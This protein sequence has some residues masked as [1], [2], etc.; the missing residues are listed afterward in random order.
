[1]NMSM[2]FLLDVKRCSGCQ[3]CI[4][5]CMDQ[6]DLFD[7]KRHDFWRQVF[8]I[9]NGSFP[10]VTISFISVACTQCQET[11]CLLSCPT[12]AIY[13]D[14]ETGI[15][16][17]RQEFCIGCHSCSLACPFGVP[18]FDKN[19]KMEKCQMCR[20]RIDN[21]LEPACV[22]TCPTKALKYGDINELS[23]QVAIKSSSRILSI[24][25]NSK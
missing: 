21:G 15:I 12:G 23:Q 1:M 16:C 13:K 14:E 9:E 7:R 18:R 2:T 19:G 22:H 8:K 17:I 11:P 24:I 4:V 20:E 25:S 10:E 6:N 5:A 3:A